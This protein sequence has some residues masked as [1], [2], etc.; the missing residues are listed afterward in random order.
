MPP[1]QFWVWLV[2]CYQLLIKF[3]SYAWDFCNEHYQ[4]CN[5]Q[6][7]ICSNSVCE[8]IESAK[9]NQFQ[10]EL[11]QVS[12]QLRIFCSAQ[13][14]LHYMMLLIYATYWLSATYISPYKLK[15]CWLKR[16]RSL[17]QWRRELIWS[18]IFNMRILYNWSPLRVWPP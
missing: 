11:V 18:L 17:N 9:S 5:E 12:H 16:G 10:L 14:W 3:T 7:G 2:N 13:V 6:V 1:Y 15:E 8:F 4:I